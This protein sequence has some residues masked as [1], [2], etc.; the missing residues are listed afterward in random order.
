MSKRTHTPSRSLFLRGL[1]SCA[2]AGG[3]LSATAQTLAPKIES[4][5]STQPAPR[6]EHWQNRLATIQNDLKAS[7]QLGPY[8]LLFVGDSITD[9]W[10][11][12]DSP[13][14]PHHQFGR[15]IWDQSFA[16]PGSIN[17]AYNLGISGDRIEHVLYRLQ[18]RAQGG[19]GQLDAPELQPDF[20]VV[21]IGINNTWAPEQPVVDSVVQ[22]VRAVLMQLH[23][24]KPRSRL[25]VQ[26][27]LP[28]NDAEKN[29]QVVRPIN[30]RI[31]ALVLTLPMA[32][33][34][35]LLDLY[36]AFV[37]AQGVQ[38][39]KLFTDGLHPN[40]AGYTVWR[41]RLVP[42]LAQLR[43]GDASKA[44]SSKAPERRP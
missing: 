13:W 15:R 5:R 29:Q 6:V 3:L 28:T 22:G 17:F 4:F 8:K 32:E 11:F 9:F 39:S 23:Q 16:T 24:L 34:I 25:L 1:L 38:I 41:D 30:A 31:Q 33:Q 43:S 44:T 20:M 10:L 19:L 18:P 35:D 26:T 36:P 14:V 40:E 37:D 7:A 12:K 42:Y 21:M 27:L 2:L